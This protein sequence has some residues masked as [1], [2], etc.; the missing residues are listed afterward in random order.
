MNTET[1][2]S[3]RGR[4]LAGLGAALVLAAVSAPAVADGRYHRLP[5]GEVLHE[6]SRSDG[7]AW[8]RWNRGWEQQQRRDGGERGERYERDNAPFERGGQADPEQRRRFENGGRQPPWN[9]PRDGRDFHYP[10][11]QG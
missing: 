4:L 11:E 10:G 9:R 3:C 5:N 6:P 7:D 2:R 8:R 1:Q